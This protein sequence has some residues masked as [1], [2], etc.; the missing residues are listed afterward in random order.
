MYIYI[1][2]Y[3]Y[4]EREIYAIYIYIYIHITILLHNMRG[5]AGASRTRSSRSNDNVAD[6]WVATILVSDILLTIGPY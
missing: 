5:V 4:R 2:I 3:I 6:I 1:Y